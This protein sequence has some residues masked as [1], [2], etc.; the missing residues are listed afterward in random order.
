MGKGGVMPKGNV[1][2]KW[3]SDFAYV[4]GIIASDGCL[5]MDYEYINV[6]SKDVEMINNVKRILCLSN[7]IGKKPRGGEKDKKYFVIQFGDR[8]FYKFLNS[9]GIFSRKS[10]TIREVKVPDKYFFDFLRGL[11]DGDGSIYSY[12]DKRWKSSFVFYLSFASA[13]KS[14]ITWLQRKLF[15]LTLVK[16]HVTH[17]R[18]NSCFQLKYAKREAG[19]LIRKIYRRKT[20]TCLLRKKLKVGQI[21]DTMLK[22]IDVRKDVS[23]IKCRAS[24]GTVDTQP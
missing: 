9:I 1:K 3:S 7:K 6:T 24:G 10:K 23:L 5:Y 8:L 4:I 22:N 19:V 12:F 21:L 15:L 2:I 13:S 16:G 18:G 17:A 14:F 11:F 20:C